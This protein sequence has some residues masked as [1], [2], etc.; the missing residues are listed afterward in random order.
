MYQNPDN[1]IVT[2]IWQWL[3]KENIELQNPYLNP[4]KSMYKNKAELKKKIK[5]LSNC[6]SILFGMWTK[7]QPDVPFYSC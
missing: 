3:F 5:Y 1:Y 6:S 2:I 7:W 4:N